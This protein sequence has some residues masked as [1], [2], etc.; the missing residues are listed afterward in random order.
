LDT[1][2]NKQITNEESILNLQLLVPLIRV[3]KN[4]MYLKPNP[5]VNADAK[6]SRNEKIENFKAAQ[7][8]FIF[9]VHTVSLLVR[10]CTFVKDKNQANSP[11]SVG[12]Y[13]GLDQHDYDILMNSMHNRNWL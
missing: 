7:P 11:F 9:L 6:I 10:S 12:Q 5:L 4:Q 3:K 13:N 8:P 1:F 2:L